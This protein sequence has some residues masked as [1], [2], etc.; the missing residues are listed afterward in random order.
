M[1]HLLGMPTEDYEMFRAWTAWRTRPRRR[2]YTAMSHTRS[3]AVRA[4]VAQAQDA[5][6]ERL[7]GDRAVDQGHLHLR[8]AAGT[9]RIADE[10]R[11][12]RARTGPGDAR[13]VAARA[14][15]PAK[16]EVPPA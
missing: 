16:A 1:C 4:G 13:E 3:A 6:V 8:A 10:Q 11:R 2:S 7:D 15:N 12:R 9:S 14:D 5:K